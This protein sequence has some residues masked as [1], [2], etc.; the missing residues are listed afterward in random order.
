MHGHLVFALIAGNWV[1]RCGNAD[2]THGQPG[3]W[4]AA[5]PRDSPD[6]GL[7]WLRQPCATLIDDRGPHNPF[8]L[9]L[10]PSI[11]ELMTA[12]LETSGQSTGAATTTF[13]AI[14]AGFFGQCR[15][16]NRVCD[17]D[18]GQAEKLTRFPKMRGP[19][20][21]GSTKRALLPSREVSHLCCPKE[22]RRGDGCLLSAVSRPHSSP[23]DAQHSSSQP[24]AP[25]SPTENSS[26]QLAHFFN[27]PVKANCTVGN[28][29]PKPGPW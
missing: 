25:N 15:C 7:G 9:A 6:Q 8:S 4:E 20:W 12:A 14:S 10:Q 28:A 16:N 23:D 11:V 21:S 3:Q 27:L 1:T 22:R 13:P 18:V 19:R 17:L 2:L 5:T 24:F 26:T 29:S